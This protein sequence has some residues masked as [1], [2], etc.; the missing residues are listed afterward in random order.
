[1]DP[2]INSGVHIEWQESPK[3]NGAFGFHRMFSEFEDMIQE[4]GA[5]MR[6]PVIRR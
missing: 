6:V 3:L 2:R 1:M 4:S 5:I